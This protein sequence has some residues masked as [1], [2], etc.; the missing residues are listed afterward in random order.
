MQFIPIT[1]IALWFVAA[2]A[3][4]RIFPMWILYAS[5]GG[6][7][8]EVIVFGSLFIVVRKNEE[9]VTAAV[10]QCQKCLK[11]HTRGAQM[12]VMK[13][14]LP[15]NNTERTLI[16]GK[17]CRRQFLPTWEQV[18]T[19]TAG[20]KSLKAERREPWISEKIV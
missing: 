20:I 11:N 4:L 19:F 8:L 7:I 14:R 6:F 2:A 12:F 9:A 15:V 18:D 17:C 13:K 10:V 3:Y 16:V 1:L 5:I